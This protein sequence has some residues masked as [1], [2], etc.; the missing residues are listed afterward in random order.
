[1]L[2]LFL[3][4]SPV[5]DQPSNVIDV[6]MYNGYSIEPIVLCFSPLATLSSIVEVP[7]L[8]FKY[9]KSSSTCSPVQSTLC[10]LMTIEM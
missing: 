9:F 8:R 4:F 5:S 7:I 10:L 2:L 1:M 6:T 3:L